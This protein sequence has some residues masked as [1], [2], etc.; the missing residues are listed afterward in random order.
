MIKIKKEKKNV[1]RFIIIK[2]INVCLSEDHW[3]T[4]VIKPV[5]SRGQPGQV[6]VDDLRGSV[7]EALNLIPGVKGLILFMKL[8]SCT[9]SQLIALMS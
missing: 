9:S 1:T 3:T 5:F 8:S 7:G 4:V 6:L 2:V